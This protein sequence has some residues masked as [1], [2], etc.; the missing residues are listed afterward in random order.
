MSAGTRSVWT[1]AWIMGGTVIACMA[2]LVVVSFWISDL[3]V[4][5]RPQLLDGAEVAVNKL[6][7]TIKN[8]H[9][10]VLRGE[11]ASLF[12]LNMVETKRL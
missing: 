8:V 6:I 1:P 10:L 5:S 7:V 11:H 2:G 12:Q 4:S 3:N 9:F